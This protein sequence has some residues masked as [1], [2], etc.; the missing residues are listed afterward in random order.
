MTDP[1][2]E[3]LDRKE[4]KERADLMA[5]DPKYEEPPGALISIP[6]LVRTMRETEEVVKEA[7]HD[8]SSS[9]TPNFALGFW[10]AMGA[11]RHDFAIEDERFVNTDRD[12][13][14]D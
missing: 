7:Q 10:T 1:V 11:I 9:V 2:D 6:E 8:D 5:P 14:R 4:I 12:Y 3:R 13:E